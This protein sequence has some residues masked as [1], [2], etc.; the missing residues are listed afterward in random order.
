MIFNEIV[1]RVIDRQALIEVTTN[2]NGHL[3][4]QVYIL[5]SEGKATSA[6]KGHTYKKLLCIAFDLAVIKAHFDDSFPRFVYHDGIFE[7]LDDRKKES[8][9]QIIR[10]FSN[11]GVQYIATSIDSDLPALPEDQQ[12]SKTE[13]I[14]NLHDEGDDGRLF[15]MPSW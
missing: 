6:S 8:L 14:V 2:T 7:S 4:F 5:N 9:L 13:T 15:K 11:E 1:E 12:I 10:E 3:E